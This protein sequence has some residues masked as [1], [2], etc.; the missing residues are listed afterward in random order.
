MPLV[1][2]LDAVAI[3]NEELLALLLRHRDGAVEPP[4][5]TVVLELVDHV[6]ERHEGVVDGDH[7]H[8]G[9]R[10]RGTEYEP[11]NTTEAVDAQLCRPANSDN[12]GCSSIE[13]DLSR[14]IQA[15]LAPHASV[16][17]NPLDPLS[18]FKI[19]N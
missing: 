4:V 9:I 12:T 3:D 7:F 18:H 17:S 6:I 15:P 2:D 13:L 8:I 1:E 5:D 11:S 16:R 10:R 14:K 19:Q